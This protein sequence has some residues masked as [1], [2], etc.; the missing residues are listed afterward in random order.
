MMDR[1]AFLQQTALAAAAAGATGAAAPKQKD[2]PRIRCAVLGIDH[3]HALDV[4]GVLKQSN[5]FVLAGVCEPDD[6][7]RKSAA[8]SPE[9]AGVTWLTRDQLLGDDTIQMVAAEGG[10]ERLLD[11]GRAVIDANKHLHLDK[12]PGVSLE[13]FA[14]LLDA[15]ARQNRIVQMGYMF[16]YNPGFDFLRQAVKEGWLGD[17]HAIHASMCTG[18]D[19]KKRQ[20]MA[21]H[22]GG[23]MLELGCHLIDMLH[24]L[25]GEPRAVT[26]FLRHD[27]PFSDALS[28]NTAAVLEFDRAMATIEVA[29][30][31]AEAFPARRFKVAGTK[32]TIILSPLEPAAA[33]CCFS[34]P[35]PGFARGWQRREFPDT[36]RHV[37]DFEELAQCIRGEK[38]FAYPRAHD[39][40]VQRTVLRACGETV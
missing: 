25:L 4:L 22:K 10:T 21:F 24:L 17:V 7:I 12:P 40:A 34:E 19:A 36:E 35:P 3:A 6:T 39:L 26:P 33:Q 11:L 13:S 8:A 5:D 38:T 15:A 29:A 31:E 30:M 20:R 32:G 2:A 37:R 18:L 16:R 9:L 14:G 27:G 23:V 1:R 28:D